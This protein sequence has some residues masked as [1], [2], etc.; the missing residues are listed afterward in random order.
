MRKH[1]LKKNQVFPPD[2]EKLTVIDLRLQFS[3]IRFISQQFSRIDFHFPRVD[4]T[5][6]VA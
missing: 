5:H 6:R 3:I 2:D 4:L 1:Y